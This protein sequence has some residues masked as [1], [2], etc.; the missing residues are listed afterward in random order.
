MARGQIIKGRVSALK[1][2]DR[3]KCLVNIFNTIKWYIYNLEF[4]KTKCETF[5]NFLGLKSICAMYA[6][7]YVEYYSYRELENQMPS[8]LLYEIN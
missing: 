4:D 1:L 2:P 5:F 3:L 7:D 6:T 8:Y